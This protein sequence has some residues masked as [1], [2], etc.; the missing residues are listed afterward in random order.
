MLQGPIG[1][2]CLIQAATDLLIWLPITN[3]VNA[4]SPLYFNDPQAG[5]YKQRFYR[6]VTMP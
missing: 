4:N 6:A 5:N 3:F 2:N 1:S